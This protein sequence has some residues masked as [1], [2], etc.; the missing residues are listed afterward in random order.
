MN[1]VSGVIS[2][3]VLPACGNLC[4]FCPAM[5][6]RSRQPVKR[7]KKLISDIFPRSQEEEPNDRKIGKLCEY[8]AKNPFRIP[9]ITKSLEE[10]CYKELRNEN[11]RSAKVVMCIYKKLVVSCKEHMPLFANSLL[12]IIQ[13][14][15]DQ[16]R[17]NDM[18]IVGCE[19]LFDFVNNQK[20]GTYMF[21]LDG[22]IPKLCQLAQQIGEEESAKHLHTVGLKALSAMVWFMGEYSHVS[23]E[24]D[25]IVSVVLE[26]YPRPRKE[27]QDSNQNRWVEEVRKVEGHVSPSPDVIAKVPSWR[28]IVNE[29]GELNISKEDAEN[30]SFWSRICLHNIAKLGKE[31]TTTRRVLESL[32]CYFDDDNLWPTETGIALPILKDMQYTMDASGENAHLLLSILVKHLDHKNVLKQPEMQLDIVQVVTSLA[33]T[34]KIHHSM[35]L[36]SAV[37]DIMRHLRKSIHYTLDDAKL[38]AELIKWNRSFQEAVDEC[39]VELSNK[40]GDAGPILDVMAVMLENISSIKVIARTTIAAAYRASQIIAS[41]P[42][43]SYQNKAFP[44]ALFHQ[45]L[46][47]MVHPD[48][49][50]RVGAHRIFSVVLVPSSVSPQKIPEDTH[51]RKATDFSRALSRTVSVFS[52]SAALFGKLRDQ[53]SSSAENITLETEQKD[54]NSGMLNRI[55]STYSGVYNTIGSPAPVGECTNKSS[56][57]AGPKSLRLSSHQIV[58]LLSSLWVQSISPANMPEN[59]E[60]IAHTF[61]LVLLFSRAKHS[62]REALVQSFQL[63]F[64]LRNVA[65]VEGG[66]LP[67]SRKRSLFVL[68]TSMILFSSKAYNIPSL[69]PCVKATLSDKTVDPFLH[70]VE[71]SKLQAADSSSGYGKVIYGSKEDDSSAQK[72]L[73]QINITEEQSTESLVSLILKSL[74]NLPDFEVSA[75]REE[76]L[77][78][79]SPDDSD[80]LGSQFLADAQHRVQQSN[81]VDLSSIL[82]DD[83]PDLSQSSSKQNEQSAMEIPNL[84]SVNQLL[85]SVLE[86]AH[87]VG[88]ISLSNEPDFSYKEMTHHCETLLTGKQQRMYNLMN[89]QHRQDSALIRISQNSSEQDKESSSHN[90]VENQGQVKNQLVDQKAANVSQKPSPGTVDWH[91]GAQCQSNPETFRLPASSPY[92]NFLKAAGW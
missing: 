75:T 31:A 84:L 67:P 87:Q 59:Y 14:L 45:L 7:Y 47:A 23:A 64:S 38:G 51:Q 24:F 25:N 16:S 4:F 8:A 39:L 53:R 27:T 92:D 90:Q 13:T 43:L 89:S 65:L 12:S 42:N 15:L 35:A 88:R 34:T 66:S 28:I 33:Q 63:A 83:G 91:C 32:F 60:A 21:H 1:G 71:D 29:K 68:A 30:P 69:I 26:N 74:S 81:S 79:F 11:F 62:Y 50:T 2:R 78:E 36:V 20:D 56:K 22:F 57:E 19:A 3:Q 80:S 6:T 49:E 48:H 37:T 44:E 86:T 61:S 40:V 58:L 55:K 41:M 85:E 18:L 10:R 46:P 73:S 17:E 82:D 9:K 70:L 5:R 52:S 72:C 76:L 54:N 77:K